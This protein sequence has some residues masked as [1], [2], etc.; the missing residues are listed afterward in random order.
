MS[1]ESPTPF[2]AGSTRSW[3]K[4]QKPARN[5]ACLQE[6]GLHYTDYKLQGKACIAVQTIA[7][8]SPRSRA[9]RLFDP[10]PLAQA[11]RGTQDKAPRG[12]QDPV[13][14]APHVFRLHL[15]LL[16]FICSYYYKKLASLV[17]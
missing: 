17:L 5:E 2:G 8:L 4:D 6:S 7:A 9:A 13:H 3:L 12:T 11:P 1:T 15:Y 10:R 16:Y 14:Q